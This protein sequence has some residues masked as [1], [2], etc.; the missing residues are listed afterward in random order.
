MS[1]VR[2][3]ANAAVNLVPSSTGAVI[4]AIIRTI[5]F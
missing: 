5:S 1:G 3:V 2:K 4:V